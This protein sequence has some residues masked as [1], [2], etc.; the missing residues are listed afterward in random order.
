[1][2]I[3][4]TEA[5]AKLNSLTEEERRIV[6]MLASEQTMP[7]IAKALGQHRSMIWRKVEKIKVKLSK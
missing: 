2:K 5:K 3:N 6:E 1:M 7:N 4:W